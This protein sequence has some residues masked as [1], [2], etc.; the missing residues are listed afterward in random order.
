MKSISLFLCCIFLSSTLLGHHVLK[1]KPN[2]KPRIQVALLLDTSGS[3]DGLIEQAKSQLWRMVNEL[4]KAS[5]DGQTPDIELALYEYGKTP[6]GEANG[7]IYQLT[8]FTRDLDLVSEKLFELKTNGGDEYCGQVI[9][10]ALEELYWSDNNNDLKIV[11]IAGNEGFDQGKVDYRVSCPNA[12][13]SNLNINTIYCGDC[14]EGVK[15]LWED[16]AKKGNGE[17]LCINHN[18]KVVH[19][20]TPYDDDI[21]RLNQKLND[22]Y[23]SFGNRRSEMR[24]RQIQQD[25]NAM[26][27]GKANAV[28]RAV[29]KSK[30]STYSNA[31]WDL[32][33]AMESNEDILDDVKEKELPEEMQK[34][35]KAERKTY[36]EKKA[37][38]RASIQ[39][40]INKLNKKRTTL[41]VKK[42]AEMS[43]DK[44]N[45]LDQVMLK[46]TRE[47]AQKK[48]FI[49]SE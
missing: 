1:A 43:G 46:T 19:I 5:K 14:E 9:K 21:V 34:L 23:I 16:G 3:M 37:K 29:S 42:R 33:D 48:N 17:Y 12:A 44:S 31:Q 11:Y 13:Q 36:V 8:P 35:S 40:E 28:E 24:N 26:T 47:Q 25:A 6:R 22:T 32:V 2:T 7:F 18:N 30:K 41:V 4:A 45:T 49:F 20:P 39:A 15:L 10:T 27:Y 38:E